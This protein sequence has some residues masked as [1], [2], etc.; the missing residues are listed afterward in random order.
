MSHTKI[1]SKTNKTPSYFLFAR[2][3]AAH[4]PHNKDTCR[5]SHTSSHATPSAFS[6][7][8]SVAH[9]YFLSFISSTIFWSIYLRFLFFLLL[10][11]AHVSLPSFIFSYFSMNPSPPSPSPSSLIPQLDPREFPFLL[12]LRHLTCCIPLSDTPCSS[13]SNPKING[14]GYQRLST[15]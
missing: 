2:P 4:M 1:A 5:S 7:P 13:L 9:F 10:L 14:R 15:C 11:K 8:P 6:K 3:Y 12:L